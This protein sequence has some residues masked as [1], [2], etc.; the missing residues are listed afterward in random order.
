MPTICADGRVGAVGADW[1][2]ADVA[3]AVAL[4]LVVALDRQQAGVLAL[5]AGVGLQADASVAGGLGQPGA[6]LLVQL[7][8]SPASWSAGAKGWTWANSGQ[9]IGIISLVALSF[10]VQ[11]AQRDHA[12][13]Q[14]QVLVRQRADVAQHAGLAVVAC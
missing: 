1:D 6:Q 10:M 11:R 9:V 3:V 5:R 8:G 2:Q 14:R 12:A 13:V 7:G 4:R